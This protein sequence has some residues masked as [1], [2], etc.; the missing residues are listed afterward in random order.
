MQL[1]VGVGGDAAVLGRMFYDRLFAAEPGLKARPQA[2]PSPPIAWHKPFG[3]SLVGAG[4]A[5]AD[6]GALVGCQSVFNLERG[7]QDRMWASA[8]HAIAGHS[9]IGV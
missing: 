1:V 6:I 5:V 2:E 8:V 7:E 4:S 9:P 3:S